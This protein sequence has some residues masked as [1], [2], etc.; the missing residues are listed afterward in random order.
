MQL[1]GRILVRDGKTAGLFI[2]YDGKLQPGLYDVQESMGEL[3]LRYAGEPHLDN[4]RL[5]AVDLAGLMAERPST[6]MT[7]KEL[8]AAGQLPAEHAF[9]EKLKYEKT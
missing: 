1:Q 6:V 7:T 8:V 5:N 3:R 4:A 9:T 2:P